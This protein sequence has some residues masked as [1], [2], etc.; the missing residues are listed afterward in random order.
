MMLNVKYLEDGIQEDIIKSKRRISVGA[1]EDLQKKF[2]VR[3]S[4]EYGKISIIN[5]PAET[6]PKTINGLFSSQNK[7]QASFGSI[8]SFSN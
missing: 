6:T 5:N 8:S 3:T 4:D 7:L 1:E 2:Q